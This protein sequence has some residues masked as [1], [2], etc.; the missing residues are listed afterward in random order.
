MRFHV[1][2]EAFV[3]VLVVDTFFDVEEVGHARPACVGHYDVETAHGFDG[4]GY[5]G[6]D[7]GFGGDVGLENVEAGSC[8]RG[9]CGGD[10][11][12]FIEEILGFGCVGGVVY[13]L[14]FS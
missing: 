13:Y 4:F 2:D 7:G 3:P 8:W 6:F 9:V 1:H 5:E 10:G 14:R 12:Q 11:G